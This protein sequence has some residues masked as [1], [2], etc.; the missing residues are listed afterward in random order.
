MILADTDVLIDFLAGVEPAKSQLIAFTEAGRLQTTAI[1][2]FELLSGAPAGAAGDKVR[3]LVS[4]LVVI[5]LDQRAAERAAYVRRTL[6]AQGQSIG[7]A[8]S[9]IAG[10]ALA[11]DVPLFTRNRKHFERVEKLSLVRD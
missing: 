10:I 11:L 8:D 9:L 7:M 6:E 2:S 4:T 1:T 5:P 3:K